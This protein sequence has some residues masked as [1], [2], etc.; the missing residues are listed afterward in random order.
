MGIK[1]SLIRTCV[2]GSFVLFLNF[3]L[4]LC[5]KEACSSFHLSFRIISF[6]FNRLLIIQKGNNLLEELPNNNLNNNLEILSL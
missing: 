2:K 1:L 4:A 5:R 6:S 3:L